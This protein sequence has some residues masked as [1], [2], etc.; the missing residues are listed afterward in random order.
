MD[1][2]ICH[3]IFFII[4]ISK[5]LITWSVEVKL[6]VWVGRTSADWLTLIEENVSLTSVGYTQIDSYIK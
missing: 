3:K 5:N 4:L 1:S 6:L 2:K